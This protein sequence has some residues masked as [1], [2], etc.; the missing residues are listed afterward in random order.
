LKSECG[1]QDSLIPLIE[2]KDM[3]PGV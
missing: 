3:P 1:G 2:G